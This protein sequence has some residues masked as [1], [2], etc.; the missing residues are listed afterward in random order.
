[1]PMRRSRPDQQRQAVECDATQ[2]VSSRAAENGGTHGTN[3]LY[4]ATYM[5]GIRIPAY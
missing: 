2:F 5:V 3:N 4:R 1:M